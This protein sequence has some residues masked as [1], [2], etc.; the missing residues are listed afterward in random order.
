MRDADCVR[1]LQWALPRL[2]MGWRGFRN[3]RR[4]V[5][6]RVDRRLRELGLSGVD[7]YREYLLANAQEWEKLDELCHVTISR[8][9]RDRGVFEFLQRTVLPAL[10]D[11]LA[12][13]GAL[14]AWSAGCA[15]GEEAYT[16]VLIWRL[17]LA[18]DFPNL[19][20]RVLATD[21]DE[22]M[23]HRAR[24][25]EYAESSLQDLPQEWRQTTFV[26]QDGLFRLE[27][28]FRSWVTVRRHDLRQVAPGGPFD[29]VLCRNVAFTYFDADLQSEVAAR[30][31]A[32]TRPGGALVIGA[33]E[34]LPEGTPGFE[35]WAAKLRVYRR[36]ETARRQPR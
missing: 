11:Q 23:L 15:S 19:S 18:R 33:H 36:S 7:A 10:V 3:V 1:F 31:A 35:P 28:E 8:F 24:A 5:C 20:L 16:L 17:A 2:R 27:R 9:Y 22:T 13:R 4:Q 25:A 21:I 34:T 26:K 14:E 29:V 12:G 6:R 30:L 32:C